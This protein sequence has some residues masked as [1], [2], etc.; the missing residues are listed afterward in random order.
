MIIYAP[1]QSPDL[2]SFNFYVGTP[3][4]C[5]LVF[6]EPEWKYYRVDDGSHAPQDGVTTVLHRAVDRSA[7]ISAWSV[8][9]AMARLKTLL[10][11]RGYVAAVDAELPGKLPVLF[12]GILDGIIKDAKAEPKA[13]LDRAGDIGSIAHDWL[14]RVIKSILENNTNR[15]HELLAKFPENEKSASCCI[16]AL[17]FVCRHRIKWISTER[18]VYSL[19]H[20]VVGTLDGLCLAS[21]C[22]DK[23]CCPTEYSDR[24]TLADWKSSNYLYATYFAQTA[25]Y[26]AAYFEETG[27]KVE[28][29]F[30]IRLGKD[31]GEFETWHTE[32]EEEFQQDLDFFLH[33]LDLCRSMDTL[34]DR[35]RATKD[36]R[37]AAAAEAKAA[38]NMVACPASGEYKGKRK[39]KGCNNTGLVPIVDT[40]G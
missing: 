11:E 13:E 7:P 24:F 39:K 33:A 21:S 15:R 32:T 19:R 36:G 26:A 17:D 1:G 5:T 12:E 25:M 10:L 4:E 35:I 30:I 16:A 6:S 3:K 9:M 34:E 29:R 38:A 31:D 14:E 28:Q 23:L 8:K 40:I 2:P 22:D 18:K 20:R 37:K 27:E